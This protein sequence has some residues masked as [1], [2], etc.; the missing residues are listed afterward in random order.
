[1]NCEC[2]KRARYDHEQKDKQAVVGAA[3]CGDR[4]NREPLP[5]DLDRHAL[6]D[7]PPS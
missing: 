3:A 1:M 4:D 5:A 6:A 7:Q 2:R